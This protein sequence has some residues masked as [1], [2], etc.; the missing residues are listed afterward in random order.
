MEI[1]RGEN[2]LNW[3]PGIDGLRAIAVLLVLLAHFPPANAQPFDWLPF[4]YAGFG[5]RLFFVISGFLITGVLL[6]AKQNSDNPLREIGVFYGRRV[7]RIFPIYYLA[8]IVVWITLAPANMTWYFLYLS[9]F[10]SGETSIPY[11]G[12][13]WSLAVEEQFYLFWP[14]AVLMLSTRT[15]TILCISMVAL[16]P[17]WRIVTL[18][19]NFGMSVATIFTPACVDALS[20][21]A[22]LAI[23]HATGRND[24]VRKMCVTCGVIGF[25]VM[26][27]I[28]LARIFDVTRLKGIPSAA[29]D[30]TGWA[31]FSTWLVGSQLYGGKTG[32]L[33]SAPALLIGRISYGM[34]VYHLFIPPLVR[35][36]YPDIIPHNEL[37]Q[38]GLFLGLTFLV[39][40]ASWIIIEKPVI[41]LKKKLPY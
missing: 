3:I 22:L 37:L 13:F 14:L 28:V 9:N 31:L 6:R 8:L 35:A 7:L 24:I 2:D 25:M 41:G 12:H 26:A 40:T 20:I 16:S 5:V 21:G 23:L 39:A 4:G 36:T 38:L 15:L 10:Y 1:R 18:K 34:Y 33:L 30:P 11:L 17:I 29:I 27:T 19:L 32:P